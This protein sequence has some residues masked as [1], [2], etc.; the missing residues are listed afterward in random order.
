M[1]DWRVATLKALK[2]PV[3]KGNL[4]F[5]A[6]WQRWEGG[7]TNNSARFNW[8]N[9]THGSQYPA[10]NSVGVRVYPNFQTGIKM[11]SSVLR[12]GYPALTKLLRAGNGSAAVSDP[13][14]LADL[15]K[16]LSG[17]ATP[18]V[19]PYVQKIAGTLGIRAPL[20]P[21]NSGSPGST[22][23]ATGGIA[24][25]SAKASLGPA[26][27]Y[28]PPNLSAPSPGLT[29]GFTVKPGVGLG[30]GIP[31]IDTAGFKIINTNFKAGKLPPLQVQHENTK[32]S[33]QT[34]GIVSLAR[35][36]LGTKY[37]YGGNTPKGF[38][39]SGFAQWVYGH[40]GIKLPRVSWDQ[41]KVGTRVSVKNLRQGDLVF[42]YG[43]EHE[44]IY[45]GNGKFIHA[46][47]T[48]DVVKISNLKDYQKVFYTARRIA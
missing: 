41:A 22:T 11:L 36:Y 21:G 44:G 40:M 34:N 10:M 17:R 29:R 5:L 33:G 13:G 45:I 48:G 6:S 35:E 15:N 25:G 8:L 47:H 24:T 23:T 38:D 27:G 46:P 1:A 20:A 9:T 19:T 37:V 4:Q 28:T 7:H 18:Q 30:P 39:C 12:S 26:E 3:T 43:G 32:P 42:F 16:W 2:A 31:K 14:G